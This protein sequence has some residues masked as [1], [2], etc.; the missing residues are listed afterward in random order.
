MAGPYSYERL[1]YEPLS[2]ARPRRRKLGCLGW[3]FYWAI[4]FF[5]G[6]LALFV[7]ALLFNLIFPPRHTNI[8]ILGLDRRPGEPIAGRTDTMILVGIN[9]RTPSVSFLSIPRDLYVFMPDG[10]GQ[11]RIN[12]A[13]RTAE[14]AVAGSGPQAAMDCVAQ[15][16]EVPVQRFIRL[17]FQGFVNIIDAAGGVNIDVPTPF[18]DY[19][20]PTDNGGTIYVEFQAGPQHMDGER[21]LQ[22]ARIRHGS[23]DFVRAA[24]QQQIIEAFVRKLLNPLN[25]PRLPLVYSAVITS[26]TTNLNPIDIFRLSPTLLRVGVGGIQRHVIEGRMVQST[27]TSGGASVLLPVWSEI[28]PLL[29]AEFGMNAP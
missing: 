3:L 2:Q 7:L 21:A 11:N 1:S 20:Y 4:G 12:T 10:S 28:N 14:L 29:M 15:N 13:H 18:F 16:F 25:W 9:A 6:A 8:L 26:T 17:D 19:E 27:T 22:Y 23:S 5:G 24:R